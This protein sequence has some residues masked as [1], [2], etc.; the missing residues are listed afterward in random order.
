[1]KASFFI[2]TIVL[3]SCS[4]SK[5]NNNTAVTGQE[6]AT[7]RGNDQSLPTC[8]QKM[9]EQYRTEEKQ[10]PP[11]QIYS[12]LYKGKTVYYVTPP[13]CDFFSDLYDSSCVLIGHPDGGFTG[14]GD[15]TIN[16]FKD[17]RTN[18][19]LIWKDERK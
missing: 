9:I 10:N 1:M 5:N 3:L 17:S 8:I 2:I 18:E 12:Y 14:K 16:D 11:R 19:K 7:S 13:C 15:G 4:S 6:Q